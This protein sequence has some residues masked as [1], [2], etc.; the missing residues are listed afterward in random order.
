ME[1]E[2]DYSWVDEVSERSYQQGLRHGA[3]K[4]K[5]AGHWNIPEAKPE[6]LEY[7]LAVAEPYDRKSRRYCRRHGLKYCRIDGLF[8]DG[9]RVTSFFTDEEREDW[10]GAYPD[11]ILVNEKMA[12]GWGNV[13]LWLSAGLPEWFS[14]K[15]EEE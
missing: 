2:R 1:N 3:A 9:E 13:V 6:H 14:M 15:R 11:C 7:I 5:E 4:E 12:V 10:D 8:I